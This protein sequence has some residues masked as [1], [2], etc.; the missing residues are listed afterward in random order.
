M[1]TEAVIAV[2]LNCNARCTMCNIWQNKISGELRPEEYSR[3]PV[4]LREI[5][6]TGGEP[7]LRKDLPDIVE[8][9]SKACP[10]A[11]LL[12]NTNGYLTSQIKSVFPKI[13][14][15]NSKTAIRVSIDGY[16][17]THTK[18]R[19]LPHF[20]ERAM[21]TLSFLKKIGVR[22]LGVSFTLMERNKNELLTMFDYCEKNNYEFSLTVVSDSP[23][24]FGTGKV[25]LRPKN[26]VELTKIFHS[27]VSKNL[28]STSPKKWMRGWFYETLKRYIDTHI[29]HYDCSAGNSFFYLDSVGNVYTCHLK[30][31]LVGNITKT[32]EL[33]DLN[34]S[35]FTNKVKKCNDCWMMCSA[36]ASI[37][38]HLLKSIY[39]MLILK[40]KYN[41]NKG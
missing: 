23:I 20:F 41:F 4:S 29:R 36:R 14:K 28:L 34:F 13:L 31:W 39:E 11:R 5:N 33:T 24:Y 18:I 27:L 9:L 7:F 10:R 15:K 40:A 37:K 8:V 17:Q 3:L 2:T 12:I 32:N 21:E 22:D 26:D 38:Q 19:G 30:P 1:F 16:G 25:V 6:I 35:K